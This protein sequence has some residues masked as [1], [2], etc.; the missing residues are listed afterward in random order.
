MEKKSEIDKEG[1][2]VTITHL[3]NGKSKEI[4]SFHYSTK[5]RYRK[6]HQTKY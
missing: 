6:Y 1:N 5:R 2:K 4:I 3:R